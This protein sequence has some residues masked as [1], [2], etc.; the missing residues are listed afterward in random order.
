MLLLL[1]SI[2]P[3]K[4]A[5]AQER[6]T[7]ILSFLDS[8][9]QL[10]S[11]LTYIQ[12]WIG[13]SG[14]NVDTFLGVGGCENTIQDIW[15][16]RFTQGENDILAIPAPNAPQGHGSLSIQG[17]IGISDTSSWPWL[18]L[19]TSMPAEAGGGEIWVWQNPNP[20]SCGHEAPSN[21]SETG[22]GGTSGLL[23]ELLYRTFGSFLNSLPTIQFSSNIF[24]IFG[25]LLLLWLGLRVLRS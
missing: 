10:I 16:K 20:V 12:V 13:Y 9:P 11:D 1:V 18:K 19:S 14:T 4:V 22:P 25:I 8:N 6:P 24:I 23:E 21:G 15:D 2:A 3:T 7:G 5:Q 17:E